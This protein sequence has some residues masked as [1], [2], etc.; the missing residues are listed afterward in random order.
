MC[1]FFSLLWVCE[2]KPVFMEVI[3]PI[4]YESI[5]FLSF[6]CA[7]RSLKPIFSSLCFWSY[8]KPLVSMRKCMI[9]CFR[10]VFY[11][12]TF[13]TLY[14]CAYSFFEPI[15]SSMC[16]RSCPKPL[17]FVKVINFWSVFYESILSQPNVSVL[18]VSRSQYFQSL[19]FWSYSKPLI[20][21]VNVFFWSYVFRS[22]FD[23][24]ILSQSDIFVLIFSRS[25]YFHCLCFWSYPEHPE[26]NV[27]FWF[28]TF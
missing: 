8:P 4:F 20:S 5:Y 23:N 2:S 17:V 27:F 10:N 9:L 19:C 24:F 21:K 14:F 15:S 1:I 11:E 6:F 25:Q 22:I 16:L 7:H 12:Y 28:C 26:I 3:F 13:S 18:I